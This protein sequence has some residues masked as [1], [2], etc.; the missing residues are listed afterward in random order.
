MDDNPYR[1]E[2]WG[3]T[4]TDIRLFDNSNQRSISKANEVEIQPIY[5]FILDKNSYP[6]IEKLVDKKE[7][8]QV[9]LLE[10]VKQ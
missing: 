2:L 4:V 3:D 8:E 1:I 5:K 7:E 10:Q 9:E 6:K